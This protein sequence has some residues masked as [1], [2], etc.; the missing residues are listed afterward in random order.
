MNHRVWL[1]ALAVFVFAPFISK[2]T[3]A[4]LEPA[5]RILAV[6]DNEII[7]NSDV[8]ARLSFEV[9]SLGMDQNSLTSQK[10]EEMSMKIL[11]SMIQDK[12]LLARA[13]ED[14]I[15]VD[16]ERLEESV[17]GQIRNIRAQ[18]GEEALTRE[19]E[20][21]GMTIRELRNQ[22]RDRFRN[23]YLR[24]SMYQS[25]SQGMLIS[26]KEIDDF[27][28]S[29]K[30]ERPT[31]VSLSHILLVPKPSGDKQVE[32]RVR[33]EK[34]LERIKNGED[35]GD[36]ARGHSEDPGSAKEGGDLGFFERGVMVP[37]FEEVAFS[38][39]PG[40]V[41]DVV[42][43]QLGYHIIRLEEVDRIRVRA[44]HILI[45]LLA[46]ET[47]EETAHQEALDLYKMIQSGEQFEDLAREHSAHQETA[48]NG[49]RFPNIFNQDNLP[50]AF[51]NVIQTMK[52]GDMS[53]PVKTELGWHL[54]KLNDDAETAEEILK[55]IRLQEQFRKVLEETR[56]KLY[57]D[58]RVTQ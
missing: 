1:T 43:T 52:P 34:L 50:P 39:R 14:S 45:L 24:Q 56:E 6:V 5:D 49:G 37:G 32:A 46:N 12:L 18:H 40:E 33:A 23:D 3:Q 44:R 21:Q 4:K 13:V 30:T 20:A 29:Y 57:V 41:S 11:E 55:E 42:E 35:F 51:K 26:P 36:L 8:L 7:L 31:H 17:R 2:N 28:A 27:H 16:D 25:L 10:I 19:L 53:L 15:E 38:L 47:D 9:M 22:F 58:I 48:E 54:I